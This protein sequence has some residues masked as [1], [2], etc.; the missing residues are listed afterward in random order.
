MFFDVY[1]S[2]LAATFR[3]IGYDSEV[4]NINSALTFQDFIKNC[5]RQDAAIYSGFFSDLRLNAYNNFKDLNLFD[6]LP[7]L[8]GMAIGDHPFTEFMWERITRS[9][10]RTTV[11]CIEPG[12]I[13]AIRML[14]PN[15]NRLFSM[16]TAIFGV[17]DNLPP[18]KD[19]TIDLLIPMSFSG[20]AASIAR[21]SD[22]YAGFP[23]HRILAETAYELMR[24]NYDDYPL[25]LF[26]QAFR[27]LFGADLSE[28]QKREEGAFFRVLR[29]LSEVENLVRLERRQAIL[30]SILQN[31]GAKRV[32]I[33]N[34]KF[35][36]APHAPGVTWIGQVNAGQLS[37]LYAQSRIVLH[38]HPTYPQSIHERM[39]NAMASG[40]AVLSDRSP[41]LSR[42]FKKNIEYLATDG[43]RSFIEIIN[44]YGVEECA[45]IAEAGRGAA[46]ERFSLTRQ[47]R[48]IVDALQA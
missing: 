27:S 14:N 35:D 11:M 23:P 21:L 10:A 28:L 2:E 40:A 39:V 44:D 9:S 38:C 46:C 45:R 43:N 32:V 42:F 41:G 33:T 24:H 25:A 13:D 3:N 47:A 31:I 17:A 34:Q 29:I 26:R 16:D 12:F 37:E 5:L 36:G 4:I 20:D 30:S 15:L 7:V 22:R 6:V 8:I 1:Y 18:F 48:Q 19:R